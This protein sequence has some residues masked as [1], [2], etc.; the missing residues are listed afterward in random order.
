MINHPTPKKPI[1]RAI[2]RVRRYFID[3]ERSFYQGNAEWHAQE[4]QFCQAKLAKLEREWREVAHAELCLDV[5]SLLR[6]R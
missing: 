3:L 5:P 1:R 6:S 2:L 4:A